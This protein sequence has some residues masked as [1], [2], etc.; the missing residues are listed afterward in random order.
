MDHTMPQWKLL[1]LGCG[2]T[3]KKL[4]FPVSCGRVHREDLYI[5]FLGK[6]RRGMP[7]VCSRYTS[8]HFIFTVTH[9]PALY[10]TPVTKSRVFQRTDNCCP[11]NAREYGG[12][13]SGYG[14]GEGGLA[15]SNCPVYDLPTNLSFQFLPMPTSLVPLIIKTCKGFG[16]SCLTAA[17]FTCRHLNC[18]LLYSSKSVII[19]SSALCPPNI[20][21]IFFFLLSPFLCYLSLWINKKNIFSAA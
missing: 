11:A 8:L 16:P 12:Q 14:C 1:F 7:R 18:S 3:P 10:Y 2:V 17:W 9:P 6:R 20:Y 19:T 4:S 5:Q 21:R 15:C 13:S